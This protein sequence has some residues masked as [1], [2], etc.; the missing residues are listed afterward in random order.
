MLCRPLHTAVVGLLAIAGLRAA[1]LT[2]PNASFESPVTTF[3]NTHINSW[4]KPPKPDWY[5]E[6]GGYYWDQLTGTFRNPPPA[7]FDHIINCHGDQAVWVFA[8]PE[9]G[10]FQDYDSVAWNETEPGRAFDVN[11]LPG[12]S[13]TLTA[14]VIGGGGG[15]RSGVTLELALYHRD[16]ASNQIVVASTTITNDPSVFS[17]TIQFLDFE[18]RTP[19]VRSTD[20]WAGHKLGIRVRSTVSHEQQGGYWDVDNFRL[21]ET[22]APV[23]GLPVVSS[24]Q[25]EFGVRSEPGRVLE[26][27]ATGDA[28]LPLAQWLHAGFVTNL[29]GTA[30]FSAPQTG[31]ARRFYQARELP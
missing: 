22:P 14:G 28:S 12:H 30:T 6:G 25:L 20:P 3:V 11:F 23:L 13:Y 15:M 21:V 10:F 24:G 27:L 8:V 7:N 1:P 9:V 18:V 31:G 16:G 4:Q 2:I 29:T 19:T 5:V 17:N 26:I